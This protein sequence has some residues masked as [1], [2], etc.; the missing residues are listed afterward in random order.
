ME[1]VLLTV[2]KVPVEDVS[3][4]E[5][6]DRTN[7]AF[8]RFQSYILSQ[9]S[10]LDV[11]CDKAVLKELLPVDFKYTGI[12]VGGTPDIQIDLEKT[13][14]LPFEKDSYDVVLCSDV[15]EHLDSLHS[16]FDELVRVSKKYIIISLPNNWSCARKPIER[17]RGHFMHYGL[18]L[19]KPVDRHKW[20]FSLSEAH[21]FFIGKAKEHHLK[22]KEIVANDK[23][24]LQIVTLLRKLR[25]VKKEN[26]LNRYAHTLWVVFEK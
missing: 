26:Y 21:D 12:D 11:G 22:I 9:L 20:F 5:R 8:R 19:Q 7:Y 14:Q 3:I 1:S 24:R 2:N 16:T 23:P 13:D 15:L 6:S 17:G 4:K 18:P 10:I 25:W